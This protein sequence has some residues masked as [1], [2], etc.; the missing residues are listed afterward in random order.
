MKLEINMYCAEVSNYGAG[1]MHVDMSPP[2]LVQR[3]RS[4]IQ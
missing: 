4:D 2:G 3:L 1:T